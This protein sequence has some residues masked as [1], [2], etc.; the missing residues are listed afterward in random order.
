VKRPLFVLV[1]FLFLHGMPALAGDCEDGIRLYNQRNYAAANDCFKRCLGNTVHDIN[2]VYYAALS[3]Q[4]MKE[5]ERAKKLFE[6]IVKLAPKS[7]A[8]KLSA[9]AAR[10][11]AGPPEVATLP[12]ETWVPFTRRGSHILIDAELNQHPVKMIFDTG[13][14]FCLFSESMLNE[15]GVNV[16]DRPPDGMS[17][18]VGK[19]GMTP[20]WRVPVSLKLGRIE[21]KNFRIGMTRVPQVVALLGRDFYQGF[22][23]S[24]DDANS[25]IGFKR[26]GSGSSTETTAKTAPKAAPLGPDGSTTV[27]DNGTYV[28]NVPYTGSTSQIIV[29][30]KLNGQPCKMIFDTGAGI[31]FFTSE[32][33]AKVGIVL[34]A[35]A[36]NVALQ[37][38]GGGAAAQVGTINSFKLGTIELKE[39]QCAIGGRSMAP[40]PLLGQ[41]FLRGYQYTI[42]SANKIIHLSKSK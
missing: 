28:Y 16:P 23:Y 42:D 27:S 15:V 39:V 22:E 31:C 12:R 2:F 9:V 38:V 11:L 7:E 30:A 1:S 14:D 19:A 24:I 36:P 13:A 37:G 35:N 26:I 25:T 29:E 17:G 10:N 32:Q 8:A 18:G 3:A 40:Y 5:Y 20:M 6:Q 33:A 41:T 4:Q 34:P 21:R